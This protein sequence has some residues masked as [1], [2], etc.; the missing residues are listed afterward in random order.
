MSNTF[1]MASLSRRIDAL[2]KNRGASLRFGKVTE[3][4]G[5]YARVEIPDGEKVVS[6]YLPTVQERVLKDQDIKMPDIGE[7]VA[8]LFRG[9]GFEEG[10]V[11]GACYSPQTPDP[12]QEAHMDYHKYE[13][14]TEL[15]YDRKEHK[16]IAKVKGDIEAETEKNIK[17]TVGENM[18]AT[19]Q[20][21]VNIQSSVNITLKAPTIS[22]M[23]YLKITDQDGDVGCSE[24]L[25]D[26][27]VRQGELAVPDK[28]IT[29]GQN[30][31]AAADVTAGTVSLREHIHSGVYAGSDTSSK[32]VGG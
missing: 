24:I 17:A 32:P 29:T 30:V 14:G 9:Q 7:P 27:T 31:Q 15:W 26:C 22:L 3:V 28:N 23:G 20:G 1:D 11:L 12:E 5:G 18:E 2:E 4:K 21:T 13:D 19:V 16:L 10:L 8:C 6:Y 25:G